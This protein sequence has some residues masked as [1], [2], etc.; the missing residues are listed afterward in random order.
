MTASIYILN[1]AAKTQ[2]SSNS[3][4]T[5]CRCI[6]LWN[7]IFRDCLS[8]FSMMHWSYW[9]LWKISTA[10][11]PYVQSQLSLCALIQSHPVCIRTAPT[12]TS[13]GFRIAELLST[14]PP[15]LPALLC[16]ISGM[17]PTCP[18]HPL[19]LRMGNG[20]WFKSRKLPLPTYAS[21]VP[22]Y[23]WNFPLTNAGC[24]KSPLPCLCVPK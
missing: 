16:P 10:S 3:L 21:R 4:H 13:K 5:L 1:I 6:S 22:T 11:G 23:M 2:M 18:L 24:F 15:F 14:V 19:T 7:L 8:T 20:D 12:Y 17:P 9:I